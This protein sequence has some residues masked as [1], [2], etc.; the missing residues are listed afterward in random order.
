[1]VNTAIYFSKDFIFEILKLI[2]SSVSF[3]SCGEDSDL[4]FVKVHSF[5]LY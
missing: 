1:M 2:T 4:S 5:F 3:R